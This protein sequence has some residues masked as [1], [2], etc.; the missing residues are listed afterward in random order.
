VTPELFYLSNEEEKGKYVAHFNLEIDEKNQILEANPL[1][2]YQGNII[3]V[4]KEKIDYIDSSFYQISSLTSA[5]IPFFHHNDATRM[6]MATNMQRQTVTLLKSQAPLVASGI[7]KSLLDNSSFLIKT[8]TD[9]EVEYQD[10]WRIVIR[11]KNGTSKTYNLKQLVVS[12]KNVLNFSIPLVK[13][14]EKVKKGQ[15]IASGDYNQGG[16]LALGYNL[17]VAYLC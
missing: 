2:R 11:E 3:T 17:R 16:E 12:N 14:G 13:K 8:Q 5:T 6:L 9:G 1:V 15:I 7:E 4:P 10:S